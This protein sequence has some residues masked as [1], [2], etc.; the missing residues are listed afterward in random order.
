[1]G[2]GDSTTSPGGSG[3]GTGVFGSCPPKPWP[4]GNAGPDDEDTDENPAEELVVVATLREGAACK[5]SEAGPSEMSTGATT[6][7]TGSGAG[8]AWGRLGP[9]KCNAED[10]E[11]RFVPDASGAAEGGEF[12]AAWGPLPPER[13]PGT[14]GSAA[15]FVAEVE[16]VAVEVDEVPATWGPLPPERDPGTLGSG[17]LYEKIECATPSATAGG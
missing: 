7:P 5:E 2:V 16:E 15:L 1:M 8:N 4:S 9:G 10:G 12:P 13:D 11:L 6:R 17:D 14:S 3:P